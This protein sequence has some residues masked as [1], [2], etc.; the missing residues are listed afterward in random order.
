MILPESKFRKKWSDTLI[1]LEYCSFIIH[2][3]QK[4]ACIFTFTSLE[5]YVL[6]DGL[7]VGLQ[8]KLRPQV[9]HEKEGCTCEY[10]GRLS[11]Q[12]NDD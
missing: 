1:C 4:H 2:L 3:N 6:C 10:F 11:V 5:L 9:H 12:D 8:T 7:D